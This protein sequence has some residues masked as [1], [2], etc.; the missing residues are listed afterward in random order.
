MELI[1]LGLGLIVNTIVKNKEV[2]VVIDDFIS[3]SVKWIR[4]WFGKEDNAGIMAKLEDNPKSQEVKEE[5]NTA[6]AKMAHN[7]Q[8]I[9]ELER[10]TNESTKLNP[11]MKNVLEDVDIDVKGNIYIGDKSG[12]EQSYDLKN[13]IKKGKIKGGGD[14][15]LGDM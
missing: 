11:S 12:N 2:N 9:K 1:S 15:N 4:S 5:L 13:L 8:F 14:F 10:W 3:D 7:K 6:M